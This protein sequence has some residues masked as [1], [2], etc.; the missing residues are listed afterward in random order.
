MSNTLAITDDGRL[1]VNDYRS[2]YAAILKTLMDGP[3]SILDLVSTIQNDYI[4]FKYIPIKRYVD[5]LGELMKQKLVVSYYG[6]DE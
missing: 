2:I 6:D 5:V 1:C 4:E 3:K